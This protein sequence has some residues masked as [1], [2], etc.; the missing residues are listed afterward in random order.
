M[1]QRK[2]L[3]QLAREM[4]LR[5][6]KTIRQH[7]DK[8]AQAYATCEESGVVKRKSNPYNLT[9]LQYANR[10]IGDGLRPELNQWLIMGVTA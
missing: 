8:L 3:I 2:K 4:G 1:T 9:A 7:Q 10:L 5:N 6:E